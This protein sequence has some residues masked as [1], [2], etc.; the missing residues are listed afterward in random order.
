MDFSSNDISSSIDKGVA[1]AQTSL[2]A[3]KELKREFDLGN[4]VFGIFL[5]SLWSDHGEQNVLHMGDKDF[6]KSLREAKKKFKK[7][8]N[9]NDVQA[10]LIVSIVTDSGEKFI[11]YDGQLP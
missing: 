5:Q 9:R 1:F 3:L 8:N 4:Y 10:S 6:K 7:E 2:D 11:L